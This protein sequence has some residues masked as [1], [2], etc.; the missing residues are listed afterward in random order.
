MSDVFCILPWIHLQTKPAGEIKPCCRFD[1]KHP[2]YKIKGSEFKFDKFNVDNI[3]FTGALNSPEW[4][5]IRQ[6][7]VAGNPVP[8]CRKCYQEETSTLPEV[9]NVRRKNKSMREKAN[10]MWNENNQEQ[11]ADPNQTNKIRYIELAFGNHCN[12]KCRTC[13]GSLS[14]TWYDDD[15]KLASYYSD[16]KFHKAVINV[17]NNWDIEDFRDVEEIKFTGGEPMLHPNFIEAID[18]II[19]TGRQDQIILDIFSNASWVPK[20]KVLSRLKQFKKVIVNL[21]VDGVGPV[22]DYIRFPSEWHI[23][24][25]SVRE[26]LITEKNDPE[27]IYIKWAPV[28]SIFNVWT[29]H[30]MLEWWFGLQK[31]ISNKEWWDVLVRYYGSDFTTMIINILYDPKY[32]SPTLYPA[33]KLLVHKLV[34]HRDALLEQMNNSNVDHDQKW[35]AELGLYRIYTNVVNALHANEDVNDEQLKLFVE[36]TVDL[37]KIRGQDLRRN[38]PDLWKRIAGTIEYKGRIHE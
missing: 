30:K 3:S 8:G 2:D 14:T 7:I 29:F 31:E 28:L 20:E 12:L 5:E 10:L 13:N 22:N 1:I 27:R 17:D 19:S 6:T 35:L 4:D 11:L 33:K 18:M 9:K 26:W 15:N 32:L 25:S 38:L 34:T 37:D 24:E 36:Y 16:R 21:S 23:V